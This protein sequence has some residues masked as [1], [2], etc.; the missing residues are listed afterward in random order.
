MPRQELKKQEE[1]FASLDAALSDARRG[2]AA[3]AGAPLS[4]EQLAT[5]AVWATAVETEV[6]ARDPWNAAVNAQPPPAAAADV[7]QDAPAPGWASWVAA[8]AGRGSAAN[9]A[10]PPPPLPPPGPVRLWSFFEGLAAAAASSVARLRSPETAARQL[11]GLRLKLKSDLLI[12]VSQL[13]RGA[14]ASTADKLDVEAMVANLAAVN[15]TPAPCESSLSDGRWNVV[16]TTSGQLLGTRLPGVLRPVGPLYLTLNGGEGRAGLDAT[17]PVKAE[18]A[19]LQLL[20]ATS[21]TLQFET[22][23]LFGLLTLPAASRQREYSYLDTVYLDLDLRI[24]RGQGGTLYVLIMDDPFFKIADADRGFGRGALPA[25]S[26][27]ARDGSAGRR[28]TRA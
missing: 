3:E 7:A 2:G 12:R 28:G 18:R 24:M 27:R 10:P 23:K 6:L 11:E 16:F 20:S 19:T 8:L 22:V 1:R 5:D 17:W 15:P 13:D 14:A 4:V 26:S 21:M 25:G 9:A